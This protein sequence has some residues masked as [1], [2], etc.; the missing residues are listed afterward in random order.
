[1]SHD[2]AKSDPEKDGFESSVGVSSYSH[3]IFNRV[4]HIVR[5]DGRKVHV[6]GSPAD[7]EPLKRKI[8]TVMPN[9]DEWDIV[10]HGSGEH[11]SRCFKPST[12][13]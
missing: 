9:E 1:M 10:I 6:A 13:G 11:V 5:P 4:R 2:P 12:R 3:E 8:S 7:V